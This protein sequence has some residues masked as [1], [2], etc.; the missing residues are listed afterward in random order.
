MK[1]HSALFITAIAIFILFGGCNTEQN[2]EIGTSEYQQKVDSL[3]KIMTL[4][5]KIGQLNLLASGWDVTGPVMDP[6]Y[7]Q[8]IKQG[9]TGAVFNAYGVGYVTELQ[10]LAVEET[11][12]GVPLLFGYDVIHGYKTI[13]PIPLAQSCSWDLEM[14][15][16][17]DRIAATEATAEGINWV[18][19]PMVDISRDPRWGRV[20]EGAGEDTWLGSKIAAARVKGF[21]GNNLADERTLLATMKH[22][23]AYGAP[24]A[25]R[26]YHTVDISERSLL[27]YYL[28]PFKACVD[29]GV[30][31][32]MTSFNEISGVPSSS[33]HWLYTELLRNTW[34]FKGFVVTDYTSIYELIPH[35]VAEDS[36]HAGELALKAGIQLDMQSSIFIKNLKNLVKSGK[37]SEELIDKAVSDILLAKYKLGLFD[38]PYRYC[39]KTRE[40]NEIMTQASKDF[41]RQFVTKSCVLLKNKNQTLPIPETVKKIALIGPLGNAAEDM[42]GNWSAAGWAQYCVTLFDGLKAEAVD[43]NIQIHYEKG[44]E[45]VGLSTSGFDAAIKAAKNADFVILALGEDRNMS[46]EAASRTNLNLPGVQMQ[47]AE[48]I[49][50]IG[51]PTAVVLFNGRPLT[52]PELDQKAPAILEAWFGGIQSGSGIADLLFGKAVPSGKLTMTFPYNVG[53][54]P[55]HYSMKNNGRPVDPTNP[56]YRFRSKYLDSP[57]QPL[58][59]FGYGLSYTNFSYSN[60]KISSPEIRATDT[61]TIQVTVSNTG[62]SD[63]EEIVQLY[64]RDLVGSVTRPVN[65]LKGFSKVFLKQGET[66]DVIFKIT[67]NDLKFFNLD[68]EYTYEPGKFDLMVGPNSAS[69]LKDS[70]S[71]K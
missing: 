20:S 23:A 64:I 41:A 14:I 1:K 2:Q 35:G 16:H 34:G 56:E 15:E 13:F 7:K 5:E 69:G 31:S 67:A 33:N 25:G 28:P 30:A 10:R 6:N 45:I 37:I 51:K 62:K 32:V 8:L 43:K 4:D 54:I 36:A 27:E 3:I 59:P 61:L 40:G 38:D 55:I 17:S 22:F 21:Q 48:K 71:L 70:F 58:Y 63:G 53:Q 50:E 9:N 24:Q 52:I 12:L 19:A 65:E 46:G 42:L 66:R 29:A 60:L 49:I 47:L 11:R 57:N 39:N 44:C 26:D 18:F 68:M